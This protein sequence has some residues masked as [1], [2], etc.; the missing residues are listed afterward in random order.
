MTLHNGTQQ[1]DITHHHVTPPNNATGQDL[2]ERDRTMR[3]DMTLRHL[4]LRLYVTEL[5]IT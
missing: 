5:N 4:T 3:L 2:I 1:C